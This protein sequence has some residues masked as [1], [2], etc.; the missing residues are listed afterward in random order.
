M[1]VF[2]KTFWDGHVERGS[3]QMLPFLM[4]L[5]F[6]RYPIHHHTKE[7][8]NKGF[9]LQSSENVATHTPGRPWYNSNSASDSCEE[10]QV[11][12]AGWATNIAQAGAL[13]ICE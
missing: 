9:N 7:P 13:H 8:A 1:H 3:R 11:L 12:V 10:L 4:C 6:G 5:K 2:A